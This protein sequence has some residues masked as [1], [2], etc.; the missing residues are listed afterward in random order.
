[1]DSAVETQIAT[2]FINVQEATPRIYDLQFLN[3]PQPD[4]P[5][6]VDYENAC[7]Y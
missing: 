5:T 7:Y 6:Q 4:T 3:H 1:M 2:T